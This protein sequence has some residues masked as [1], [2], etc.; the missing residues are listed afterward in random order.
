MVEITS[1]SAAL[2]WSAPEDTGGTDI[3]NYII[4]KRDTAGTGWTSVSGTCSRTV[5]KATRLTQ[6]REYIFRVAAENKYGLGE[7]VQSREILADHPF[8]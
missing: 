3:T 4:E 7:F 2:K 1:E 8:R 5:I 6:G